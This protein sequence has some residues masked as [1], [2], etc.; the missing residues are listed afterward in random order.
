[1]SIRALDTFV[2]A[3]G[4][5]VAMNQAS[6]LVIDEF[7]LPVRN[8]VSELGRQDFF[9]SGSIME[10]ETDIAHPVMAGMPERAKVFFDRSPV[11]TTEEGF[12]G[13][14]LLKYQEAGSPLLSGYLLGEEHIQ[15]YAAALDVRYGEGHVVLL[16]FRPQ[17]RG[18]PFGTFRA[19]FNSVLYS[20]DISEEASGSEGFWEAPEDDEDEEE[21]AGPPP[22]IGELR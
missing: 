17:W 16:G 21:S 3:G 5:L 19:L 14:A 2:R 15:G 8:V 7:H 13:A 6:D 11:F 10:V 20:E 22:E 9:S 4:T 1:M 12:E 18:Q